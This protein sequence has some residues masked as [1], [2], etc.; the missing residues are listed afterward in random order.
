MTKKIA[1]NSISI[2]LVI[3]VLVGTLTFSVVAEPDVRSEL[4]YTSASGTFQAEYD[5]IIT[6]YDHDSGDAAGVPAGYSGYVMRVQPGING[7]YAGAEFNFSSQEIPVDKIESITFRV[8]LPAGHTEMRLLGEKSPTSWLMRAVPSSF[9]AWCDITLDAD[10]S[11]F[12]SGRG[13][14]DFANNSGNLGKI[15]LI[16]RLGNGADKSYYLDSISIVYKDGATDDTVPPVISCESNQITLEEGTVY[17]MRG[18]YAYDE[19]DKCAATIHGTWSD[20]AIAADG[21][22]RAGEHTLTVIA[23]DRS[24]NTSS[25]NITA[26]VVR[27]AS[28]ITLDSIPYTSYISGVSIYDGNVVELSADEA[29]ALNIPAGYSGK[30]LKVSS[31]SDRF[32]MTFDPTALNIPTDLIESM[33]VR[34]LMYS[35]ENAFRISNSGATSWNVLNEAT[36]GVWMD[37]TVLADGTGFASGKFAE[38]ADEDGDLGIFGIATKDTTANKVFYIDSIVIRLKKD[39][40]SAP[41]INYNGEIDVLTSSGKPFVVDATAYDVL[42]NKTLTI[43]YSFSDGAVDK[44]G[45]L[46][47]GTHTCRISATNYYGHESYLDL[48]LTVGPKDVTAPEI[49]FDA[50][51]VYAPAGAFWCVEFLGVDDYDKVV[52][53]ERW[54]KKPTDIGG[55]LIKGEYTV[56]LIVSDLSGNTSEKTVYLHVTDEDVTVGTLIECEK[57]DPEED[58]TPE[59]PK[60]EDP[61]PEDPQPEDPK[62]EDPQTEDP[63]PEDPKPEDPKPED[64]KPE[65]PQPEDPP[66]QPSTPDNDA[67][68]EE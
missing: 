16:G 64:P 13:M 11:N 67:P 31:G 17:D 5:G 59:D 32:G 21:T 40:G 30:V 34:A 1:R 37:H 23:T 25:V 44:N 50:E 51:H 19:Y 55:R 53:E 33:T 29:A 42:S 15:C 45:N 20:D 14:S 65:D 41:V 35:T 61:K 3:A 22:L 27:D 56:V 62:P 60:P 43:S 54:S 52:V 63:K 26:T 57:N 28:V 24:G 18:I 39:D 10:G 47:E 66:K 12:Q 36:A 7:A 48:N 49:L 2:L 4:P 68:F 46:L 58:P 6:T 8:Y 9:G 38:L